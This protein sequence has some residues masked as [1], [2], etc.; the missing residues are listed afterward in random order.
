M[1]CSNILDVEKEG[2]CARGGGKSK[3]PHAVIL[4]L[5]MESMESLEEDGC[6]PSLGWTALLPTPALAQTQSSGPKQ[7]SGS[8]KMSSSYMPR[9]KMSGIWWT[10]GIVT[11]PEML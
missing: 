6:Q 7:E 1:S 8:W 10:H 11:V 4:H 5:G 2:P 9:G 3:V